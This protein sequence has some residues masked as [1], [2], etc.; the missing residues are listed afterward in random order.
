MFKLGP[1]GDQAV[2]EESVSSSTQGDF[3]V[4]DANLMGIYVGTLT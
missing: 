1:L 4:E 3:Y 2:S